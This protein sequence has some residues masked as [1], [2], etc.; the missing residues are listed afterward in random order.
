ML[1]LFILLSVQDRFLHLIADIFIGR[2]LQRFPSDF[3]VIN[4]EKIS[5]FIYERFEETAILVAG[6]KS[7]DFI[8]HWINRH[9]SEWANFY[10]QLTCAGPMNAKFV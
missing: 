6:T 9:L 10:L 5:F 4:V 3:S 7:K 1:T 8:E 2:V